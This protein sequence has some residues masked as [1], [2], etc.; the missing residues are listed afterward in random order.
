MASV[1]YPVNSF[2]ISGR[3]STPATRGGSARA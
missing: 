3:A 1:D 2:A